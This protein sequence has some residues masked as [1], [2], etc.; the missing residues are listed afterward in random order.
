MGNLTDRIAKLNKSEAA[1]LAFSLT[2]VI[3][4]LA[5]FSFSMIAS[6]LGEGVRGE[7]WYFYVSYLL[8]SLILF[9]SIFIFFR[10]TR[11]AAGDFFSVRFSVKFLLPIILIFI[12]AYLSLS[13]VND[14]FVSFLSRFGYVDSTLPLPPFSALNFAL[15]LLIMGLLPPVLEEILFRGILVGGTKDNRIGSILAC[16]LLFSLYHMSPSKTIYQFIMGAL[17]ALIA[18]K[19]K[20]ILPSVIVHVLNN[21]AVLVIQYFFPE[22][23]SGELKIILTIVGFV[24]L[25]VGIFLLFVFAKKDDG[26]EKKADNGLIGGFFAWSSVGIILCFILWISR[27]FQ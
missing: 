3:Y 17:F 23:I 2:V 25:S 6:A 8:P 15:S 10:L 7:S 22:L 1:G 13:S 11:Y 26:I 9:L 24:L 12:G 18:I 19:T 14:I 4:V 20:S 27:F 21:V 16:A 5:A